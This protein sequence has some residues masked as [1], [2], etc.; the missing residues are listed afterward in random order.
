ML[1]QDSGLAGQFWNFA[2]YTVELIEA[3]LMSTHNI[4]FSV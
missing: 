1:Q 4:P 2:L 3:I